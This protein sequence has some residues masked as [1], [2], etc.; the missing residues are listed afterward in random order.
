MK[1]IFLLTVLIFTFSVSNAQK[2]KIIPSTQLPAAISN[3]IQTHFSDVEI[4]QVTKYNKKPKKAYKVTLNGNTK[5]E[6]DRNNKITDIDGKSELP[7]SV[8]P[9]RL[10][11]YTKTNFPTNAIT[12]WELE[13][14]NQQIELDNGLELNFDMNG[15]YL[16]LDD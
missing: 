13:D 12:D 2:K 6:F 8:I 9:A 5:L 3:Y 7:S 11:N 16:K 10:L 15:D 14:E 4:L 1:D